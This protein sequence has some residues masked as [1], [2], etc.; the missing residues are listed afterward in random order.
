MTK[1]K[2]LQGRAGLEDGEIPHLIL[3]NETQV[4]DEI[5]GEN[6][7]WMA[8]SLLTQVRPLEMAVRWHECDCVNASFLMSC[9][10]RC[11]LQRMS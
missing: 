6:K 10:C 11:F 2:I 3:N 8:M 1:E 5:T 4:P 9:I 7:E